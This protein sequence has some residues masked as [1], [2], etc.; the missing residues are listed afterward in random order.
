MNNTSIACENTSDKHTLWL[1]ISVLNA[2]YAF[3]MLVEIIRLCRRFPVCKYA[4]SRK[5]DAEFIKVY[6]LRKEYGRVET[7]SLELQKCIHHYKKFRL[8]TQSKADFDKL[9]INLDI[10]TERAPHKFSKN[11]E[12]HEIYDVY[13]KVPQRSICLKK[14]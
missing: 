6:L 7:V 8:N 13:M 3:I 1:I 12:R 2:G 10:Q 14:I 11:M 5:L 4:I 9:Y